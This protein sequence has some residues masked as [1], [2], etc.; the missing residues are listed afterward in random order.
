VDQSNCSTLSV[1]TVF[2]PVDSESLVTDTEGIAIS[3]LLAW[4]DLIEASIWLLIVFLIEFMV[5]LQGRGISSG[6][7]ITLGNFAK[8]ALYGL[9]L[10]IAAYWGVLRHWLFVWDELI[11]I[12]GF[13]AIEFNVVKWRGE[14]EEAQEP[15]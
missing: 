1:G 13:A 4:A 11:W 9:L 2:F 10:L 14:L 6:P 7:L 12:A 5:R 3:R 15:A 8:P